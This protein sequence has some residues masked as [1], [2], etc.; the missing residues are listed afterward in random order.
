MSRNKERVSAGLG[1]V[2]CVCRQSA[3]LEHRCD[4]PAVG[5]RMCG[6]MWRGGFQSLYRRPVIRVRFQDATVAS[7]VCLSKTRRSRI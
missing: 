6:A 4:W 2:L 1:D 3:A 5:T 7:W